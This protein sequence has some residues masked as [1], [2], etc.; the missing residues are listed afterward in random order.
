MLPL[1]FETSESK[2]LY[3]PEIVSKIAETFQN[4]FFNK[5][6]THPGIYFHGGGWWTRCSVQVWLEVRSI[7]QVLLYPVH[8]RT[9]QISD[10]EY[11]AKVLNT[12]CEEIKETILKDSTES[13]KN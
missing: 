7:L 12:I 2:Q 13:L 10:F 11:V 1:P 3:P 4:Q 5:W 8:V 9:R 6:N